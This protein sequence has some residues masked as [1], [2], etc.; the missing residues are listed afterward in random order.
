MQVTICLLAIV[1]SPLPMAYLELQ[2]RIVDEVVPARNVELLAIL[3]ALYL[4]VIIIK[5]GLKYA[6][7]MSKGVVVETVARNI[8]Q[9]IMKRAAAGGQGDNPAVALDAT[10]VTM[11][12]AETDD[13]SGFAGDAFAIP[14]LDL[15]TILYVVGYLLWVQPAIAV[16]AVLIYL[17]QV[18]I[19]PVT[20]R[21][22]NRL[23]RI[24][25]KLTRFLGS[26]AI[27][28]SAHPVS[29]A[30]GI[31]G[32]TQIDR[33]YQ[34]RIWIYLRK[35][36]LSELGNFLDNF[37]PLIILVAGG[38][39]VMTGKT[40]VGTLVVFIS[41]LQKIADPWDE[42]ITFYR[43]VSNAKVEYGMIR[44]KLQ[45]HSPMPLAASGAA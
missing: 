6:L 31:P 43:T 18:L 28:E 33:L 16:I 12:S 2:R 41:G 4:G 37:G 34:I 19:V 40:E 38:Y 11:L 20:Q 23:A 13:L 9:R 8:R 29:G 7:N 26:L 24:R 36:L 30:D 17:P 27:G 35:F 44:D 5:S 14:L 15:S 32:R 3:S 42:M 39:L 21:S 10:L 45:I 22:I 1:I 25:I